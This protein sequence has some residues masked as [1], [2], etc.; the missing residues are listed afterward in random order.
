MSVRVCVALGT[1]AQLA[2]LRRAR[3]AVRVLQRWARAARARG[4]ATARRLRLQPSGDPAWPEGS[5]LEDLDTPPE[6]SDEGKYH[7]EEGPWRPSL[8]QMPSPVAAE[9]AA[10]E[11]AAA[12]AGRFSLAHMPRGAIALGTV[13]D[14]M[15]EGAEL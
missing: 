14:L 5:M 2:A 10:A 15:M 6:A 11:P 1:R 9:P 3:G 4:W 13:G 12:A 8:M 7:I